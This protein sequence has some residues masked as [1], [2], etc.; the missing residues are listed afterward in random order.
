MNTIRQWAMPM[1]QINR[2]DRL[3]CIVKALKTQSH[4]GPTQ[5][6][7]IQSINTSE[8]VVIMHFISLYSISN[9]KLSR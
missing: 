3:I 2:Y 7:T 1:L 8:K 4:K 6:K 5:H 9:H